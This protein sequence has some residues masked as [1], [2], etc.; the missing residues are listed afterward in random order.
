M[1]IVV[2]QAAV[3]ADTTK[4]LQMSQNTPFRVVTRQIQSRGFFAK[5]KTKL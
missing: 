3:E 4:I 5:K 1:A 2:A